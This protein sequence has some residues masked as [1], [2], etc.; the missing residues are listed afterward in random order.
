MY[1]CYV[2]E[3]GT[4]DIPG[5]TSHYV[6]AG[7]SIPIWHWKRFEDE[8]GAIKAKY[9]LTDAEI[10]VA[11]MLR[12]YP[13]QN[14][15]PDFASKP[16]NLRRQEVCKLRKAE[17][18]RLRNSANKNQRKQTEKN[19]RNT[20]SY[21]HLTRAERREFIT[22]LARA[23]S[24]WGSA[25]LFAECTDK[26]H[27][28]P[29]RAPLKLDE[30]AF[31]QVVSRFQLFLRNLEQHPDR[32]DA[33]PLFRAN[34]LPGTGLPKTYG[35][36]IHDNNPTVASRHTALMKSFHQR[37]TFWTQLDNIIETPL[38]VDS[39]LTGM[40]QIADLCA[41]ALRRYL[42]NNEDQLFELI[43]ERAD[44]KRGVAVGVRHFTSADCT[45]KICLAHRAAASIENH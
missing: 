4:A 20:D 30:Q 39:A 35:L 25:R 7:L 44:R 17:I 26:V 43:F 5:N 6:L 41:Y 38:F 24:G 13:E 2:D 29:S 12:A 19:F 3:S 1:L 31:E 8:I 37:G 18:L 45:C 22:E 32:S 15:I 33:L 21:I 36:I 34:N 28:D 10:H 9:S 42:E 14:K 27:Y 40:V 23:V 16:P 11:W